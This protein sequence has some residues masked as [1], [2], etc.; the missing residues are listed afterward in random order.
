MGE[1]APSTAPPV[2]PDTR[3]TS[4]AAEAL[5]VA[6]NLQQNGDWEQAIVH[7]RRA[8]ALSPTPPAFQPLIVL[9]IAM[10]VY[11]LSVPTTTTTRGAM[12]AV[13]ATVAVTV[14]TVVAQLGGVSR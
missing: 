2:V 10:R 13:A 5:N 6:D 9:F 8:L 4:Q 14:G 7:Y 3:W 1:G 12:T 11:P